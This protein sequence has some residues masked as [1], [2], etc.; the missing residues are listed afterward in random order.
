MDAQKH[1]CMH[2][3]TIPLASSPVSIEENALAIASVGRA[4]FANGKEVQQDIT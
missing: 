3:Y 1:T 2:A 4:A